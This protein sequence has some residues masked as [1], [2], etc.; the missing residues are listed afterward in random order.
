MGKPEDST[1]QDLK[2]LHPDVSAYQ[3]FS[4]AHAAHALV[5]PSLALGTHPL[6]LPR[7]ASHTPCPSIRTSAHNRS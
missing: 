6:T 5:R 2:T 4:N 7:T 1:R 3:K